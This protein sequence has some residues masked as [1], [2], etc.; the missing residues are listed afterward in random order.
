LDNIEKI[1]EILLHGFQQS[2]P[3]SHQCSTAEVF[4]VVCH[5]FHPQH[6]I[7]F[8][9]DLEG[10]FSKMEFEHR[11][12]ISRSFDHFFQP[13]TRSPLFMVMRAILPAKDGL[14][15]FHVQRP[16]RPVQQLLIHLIERG[17]TIEQQVPAVFQ[18]VKRILILIRI[19]SGCRLRA[20]RRNHDMACTPPQR[21]IN[22]G[23]MPSSIRSSR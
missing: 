20:L 15:S 7:A 23:R 19:E 22:S 17:S 18:L 6:P 4:H 9:I 10:Q 11:Q 13:A 14:E 1:V 16:V 2:R 12:I 8:V 3:F 5:D 21:V